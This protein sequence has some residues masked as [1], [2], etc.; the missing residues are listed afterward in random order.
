MTIS[1]TVA[2]KYNYSLD[3]TPVHNQGE[4]KVFTCIVHVRALL[5][6]SNSVV[7][8]Y[9]VTF[10]SQYFRGR[11]ISPTDG[12]SRSFGGTELGVERSHDRN[13]VVSTML[14]S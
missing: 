13:D 7:R 10:S 14:S 5:E 3:H 12:E 8:F 9:C 2:Q 4:K 11:K 1:S 6:Q